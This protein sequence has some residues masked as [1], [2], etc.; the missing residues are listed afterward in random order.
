[1]I[2]L[3]RGSVVLYLYDLIKMFD[4]VNLV[5]TH[6]LYV[7]E[8]GTL[9]LQLTNRGICFLVN[10]VLCHGNS[11]KSVRLC[12]CYESSCFIQSVWMGR[13]T[14]CLITRACN[15]TCFP[16]NIVHFNETN[17]LKFTCITW[18]I[19][20][21]VN[22]IKIMKR[23]KILIRLINVCSWKVQRSHLVCLKRQEFDKT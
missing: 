9:C 19:Y 15:I 10:L 21:M 16:V 3:L 22:A 6:R 14:S 18:S 7:S 13:Q 1:M 17:F 12:K 23:F 4:W 8:R 2:Y 20:N 5:Y 11:V